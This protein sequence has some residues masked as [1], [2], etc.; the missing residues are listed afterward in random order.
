MVVGV[1]FVLFV[2]C[3][4]LLFVLFGLVVDSVVLFSCYL[5]MYVFGSLL[6]F[7]MLLL[8]VLFGVGVYVVC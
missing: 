8:M 6:L 2:G 7:V 1:W 5:D 3:Y 4:L